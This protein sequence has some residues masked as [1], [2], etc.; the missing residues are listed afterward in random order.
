MK[1]VNLKILKFSTVIKK[2]NPAN[3]SFLAFNKRI[4]NIKND[5]I[6]FFNFILK[7]ATS[8]AF[9]ITKYIGRILKSN[10]HFTHK[11]NIDFKI[12]KYFYSKKYSAFSVTKLSIFN[13]KFFLIHLPVSIV[14]FGFLYFLIPTFYNYNEKNIENILCKK[15]NI[16][17]SIKGKVSYNFYPTPRIKITNLLVTT[18]STT[19]KPL[20]KINQV[21]IILS[22]KNLLAKEKH[23][24]KSIKIKEYE[25][26]YNF[27]NTKKYKKILSDKIN[28]IPLKFLNG[29]VILFNGE[30]YVAVIKNAKIDLISKNNKKQYELK[31]NFLNDKIYI[32]LDKEKEDNDLLTELV[33]KMSDLN[34][35]TK[36]SFNESESE[37]NLTTGNILIK[38]GKQRFTGI[39]SYKDNIIEIKKSNLRNVF[40]EGK[41]TGEV[42]F[43]PYFDFD[44]D[45]SL[46]SINFTKLYTSFLSFNESDQKELFKI[47][48]KL[49]GKLSLSSDK[50]YSSYNL[51]KSFE[52]QIKLN[53]GNILIEQFLL[54]LGKLGAADVVG[55]ITSDKKYTNFKYETNIFIENQKKFLSK[56][57]IYNK[58]IIPTNLF[59]SGNFDLKNIKNTF[60]EVSDEKKLAQDDINFIEDEFNNFMLDEGYKKLFLFPQ[61]KNF[62]KS[63]LSESN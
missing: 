19:Q 60:Y 42:K 46:N 36:V 52:S 24:F 18:L 16:E 15:N 33:I 58:K 48:K 45:L 59:V 31:G 14:F 5:F 34:L 10:T 13:N 27:I 28:F 6:K 43:V 23:K 1:Y 49:N 40:L 41:L 54:N 35:L 37:K 8:W 9:K 4:K 25:V 32:S 61:F 12:D 62:V 47:N 17:C 30:N 56:F 20:A 38:K 2:I 21:E 63:I 57:G 53:N 3:Y 55:A 51:I 22:I 50:I 11:P 7:I 26:N 29:K 39:Y 44:L